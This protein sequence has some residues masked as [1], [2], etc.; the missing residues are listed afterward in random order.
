MNGMRKTGDGRIPLAAG[1]VIVS[2]EGVR[3]EILS[4]KVGLGGSALVYPASK[5]NS[6]R[7]FV[8][9]ECYPRPDGDN[10]GRRNGGGAVYPKT[11]AAAEDFELLKANMAKENEIGQEIARKTG[12]V[13]TAWENVNAVEIQ[14]A[15]VSYDAAESFFIVMEQAQNED[16]GWFLS[17]LLD[18]CA[19]ERDR[20]F[21]LRTG[22]LPTPHVVA[23]IMEEL[24]KALRDIHAAGYV[25]ADI[26]DGNFFLM[27]NNLKTGDIGVGKL[28]DFGNA[29]SLTGG[30]IEEIPAEDIFTTRGYSSPEILRGKAEG[31][32]VRLTAAADVFSAGCL[33]LYLLRGMDFRDNWGGELVEMIAEDMGDLFSADDAA[34]RGCS[35]SVTALLIEILTRALELEPENRYRDAGEMLAKVSKLKKL[36]LPP[37]FQLP[38]N[39]TPTPYWVEGSRDDEL[40]R[41]SYAMQKGA[42]PLFIWGIGGVGKT[43]LAMRFALSQ[44]APAFFV[45]YRGTMR[46]TV[47]AMDFANYVFVND[48]AGDPRD[49]EYRERLDILR[50]D[51]EGSLLIVDDFNRENV[52]LT[53]LKAEKAYSDIVNSGLRVIFTTRSRPD[54]VTPELGPFSESEAY[55]LFTKITR[56]DT[57]GAQEITLDA[58]EDA[59]VRKLLREI[60]YHPLTVELAAKAVC[61]NWETI[62]PAQVLADFRRN[63]LPSGDRTEKIYQQI[64]T[65]FRLYQ[66][67][68]S[69][70]QVL[71]HMTLLPDDGID[72]A[73]ILSNEDGSKKNQLKRI[74][75]RGFVRRRKGDNRLRIHPLVRRVIQSELQ[76][77]DEDCE[78]F[79]SALWRLFE[80]Q[81]PPDLSRYR[82]AA[83]LYEKAMKILPDSRGRS[84]YRSGDCFT[85]IGENLHGARNIGRALKK[86]EGTP[87]DLE[88]GK[89]HNAHGLASTKIA[90]VDTTLASFAR[91]LEIFTAISAK[92]PDIGTVYLNIGNVYLAR[93]DFTAAIE[94]ANRALD[95]F[96]H[97]PPNHEVELASTHRTLGDALISY[98]MAEL[99]VSHLR[100]AVEILRKILQTDSHV[101]L[102]ILYTEL[103]VAYAAAKI[104]DKALEFVR[105]AISIQERLLPEN[106]KDTAHS[107]F[108]LAEICTLAGRMEDGALYLE[109]AR[110]MGD[111]WLKKENDKL[112]QTALRQLEATKSMLKAKKKADA[113]WNMNFQYARDYCSLAG[114]YLELKDYANAKKN[115]GLSLELM[116]AEKADTSDQIYIYRAARNL[117]YQLDNLETALEYA[118]K[119][120]DIA[121]TTTPPNFEMLSMEY[122]GYG[123]ICRRLGRRVEAMNY[124]KKCIEAENQRP[125][126]DYQTIRLANFGIE[127]MLREL[128]Q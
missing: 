92:I 33:M 54:N 50:T 72:A 90:G 51:Y 29:R 70:R 36:T 121:E 4:G 47:M 115:I 95:F 39:L 35:H 38:A 98:G 111:S 119:L 15:G 81:Y 110:A 103:A 23:C 63:V 108:A 75:A 88:L 11:Q 62:T 109:K 27:G 127:G 17:D 77:K 102:A 3:Y 7:L 30:R 61:D 116:D 125:N 106:H 28:L 87:A 64:R 43:E 100:T 118:K 122:S 69:Y 49:N 26:H 104:F 93:E 24:L 128:R 112:R 8:V 1:T 113:R 6:R 94:N 60:E 99:A 44:P 34:E 85:V 80:Y 76:P 83:E 37:R 13:V 123:T 56:D 68:E 22:D 5:S 74:E 16:S 107:Y 89:M 105:L 58:D 66:F 46:D 65:L 97:V 71:A 96:K 120:I 86:R 126:P 59:T 45:T 14:T 73:L 101:D 124:Y 21:P 40:A 52:D 31:S 48:G 67:D 42:N 55:A 19:C 117:Y 9:K 20:D 10:F 41:L 79:L 82:Q 84:A 2:A 32:S 12:R 25:H 53:E 78:Q 57:G 91:A 18:E 114:T